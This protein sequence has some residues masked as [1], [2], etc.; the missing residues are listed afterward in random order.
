MALDVTGI[1]EID[2]EAKQAVDQ[3]LKDGFPKSSI[4][5]STQPKSIKPNNDYQ[6]SKLDRNNGFVKFFDTVLEGNPD[7]NSKNFRK[8]SDVDTVINIHTETTSEAERA[9]NILG[10]YGALRVNKRGG[11]FD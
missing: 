6:Y 1:F 5:L 7:S 11:D 3:L 2:A 4:K 9:A 8:P 10:V